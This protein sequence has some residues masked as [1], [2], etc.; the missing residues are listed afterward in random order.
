MPESEPGKQREL[1]ATLAPLLK[2]IQ[3]AD[4]NKRYEAYEKMEYLGDKVAPLIPQLL[5]NVPTDPLAIDIIGAIGPKAANAVPVLLERWAAF[6]DSHTHEEVS[7]EFCS[8]G[9]VTTR[10]CGA[11]DSIGSED[12]LVG[13]RLLARLPTLCHCSWNGIASTLG[14]IGGNN[15]ESAIDFFLE[16]AIKPF[17]YRRQQGACRESFFREE[18]EWN[19]ER[20]YQ[21]RAF[22]ALE[23]FGALALPKLKSSAPK[24]F[25]FDSHLRDR[26]RY[27]IN[28]IERALKSKKAT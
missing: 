12:A 3:S 13:D 23:I 5:A 7:Q 26:F 24:W 11:I 10:V 25:A 22:D 18:P 28:T 2:A 20:F 19:Q 1:D 14:R 17:A 9:L 4:Q 16:I 21:D 27:S 6:L 8:S 15:A